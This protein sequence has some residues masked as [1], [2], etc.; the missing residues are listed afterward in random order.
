MLEKADTKIAKIHKNNNLYTNIHLYNHL[1]TDFLICAVLGLVVVWV[2]HHWHI[3]C[4][5]F[6]MKTVFSIFFVAVFAA[7]AVWIL[8][9]EQ[10]PVF[11]P[12]ALEK[13]QKIGTLTTLKINYAN[14]IEFNKQAVQKV[15]WTQ[16]KFAYGETRV[17]LVARGVCLIGTDLQSA[18]YERMNQKNKTGVLVLPNPKVISARLNH[19]SKTDGSY[20]YTI[21]N[22]G[23]SALVAGT[24]EQTHAINQALQKGQRDIEASCAKPNLIA[25]A[26]KNAE[27]VLLPI[28]SATDWNFT[29]VWR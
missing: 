16:W 18:I 5:L 17:L 13:V 9:P 28:I 15:P 2:Y 10:A 12:P 24:E 4:I 19:D 22:T 27:T 25:T 8:K 3:N 21:D 29:I 6:A 23:I 14:V 1:Y 7:L 20:F 11:T 26:R